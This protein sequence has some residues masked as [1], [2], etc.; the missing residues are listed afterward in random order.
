MWVVLQF[1]FVFFVG[2]RVLV[3]VVVDIVALAL[4]CEVKSAN[5][6]VRREH[7]N[8]GVVLFVLILK[9]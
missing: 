8:S 2:E 1:V 3:Q 9:T 7:F 5:L 6:Q 4:S